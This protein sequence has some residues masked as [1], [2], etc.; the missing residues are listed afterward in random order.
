ME[1]ATGWASLPIQRS[2]G[3]TVPIGELWAESPAVIAFVRHFG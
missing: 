2:D 3:S 1:D